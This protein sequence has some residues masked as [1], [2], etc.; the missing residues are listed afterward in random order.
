MAETAALKARL[1]GRV[2]SGTSVEMDYLRFGLS[3]AGV[4]ARVERIGMP[5]GS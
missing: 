3:E 5:P 4:D 1:P 2:A